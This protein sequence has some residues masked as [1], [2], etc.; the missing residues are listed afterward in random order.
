MGAGGGFHVANGFGAS[1]ESPSPERM[2]AF[3]EEL[4]TTDEEHGAAWLATDAGVALEWNGD[5]RLVYDAAAAAG[6]RHL[7][8]V[9]RE[10]ALRLWIALSEGRNADIE[11]LPWRPGNGFVMTAERQAE[12]Q[13]WQ[14]KQDRDFYDSL[15]PERSEV[16]CRSSECARGAIAFSVL[17][18]SHHFESIKNRPSPFDD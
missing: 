15:G 11:R 12:L 7:S 13:E 3:L 5:G 14:R 4:D 8:G 9:S 18:R 6:P 16:R 2:R 17:C 10:E 1:I